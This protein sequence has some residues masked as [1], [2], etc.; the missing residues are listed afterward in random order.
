MERWPTSLQYALRHSWTQAL[1]ALAFLVPLVATVGQYW[2]SGF[3]WQT[4]NVA[5]LFW[6]GSDWRLAVPL[7]VWVSMGAMLASYVVGI[8]WLM[9]RR[10]FGPVV[11]VAIGAIVVAQ[12][13]GA[14]VNWLTGWHE[15]QT[16]ASMDLAG[17]ANR[18]IFA[19]WHNPV[20]EELVFRGLPL[21]FL[22][23]VRRRLARTPTWAL[24]CYYLVPSLIMA[25]YHVPGHGPSRLID[26][27]LLSLVFGW[28]ALRYTFFAPLVMHY[29]F[30]AVIVTS[31]SK[32]PSI[33]ASE[34]SWIANHSGALNSTWTIALLLW[35][36][37]LPLLAAVGR[38]RMN[39]NQAGL[40]FSA[41]KRKSDA[42]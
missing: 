18:A 1:L 40:D 17:K 27:F 25:W 9:R 2:A 12:L 31:L 13:G 3:W 33:P 5:L 35:I 28:M 22:F 14:A 23:A 29:I 42:V 4:T 15:T 41:L 10:T 32:I 19:S 39:G 6:P 34:V 26:T 20:W 38:R 11:L 30:D 7:P 21:V 8:A 37:S 16:M 36:V 24:W